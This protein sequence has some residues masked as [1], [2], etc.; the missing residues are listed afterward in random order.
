MSPARASDPAATT[1][2]PALTER[3]TVADSP[4]R[5]VYSTITTASAPAGTGAPVMIS[6][7]SPALTRISLSD[8]DAPALISPITCKRAG[9]FFVSAARTAKPS[10][11][12]LGN[13]GK[14]RSA[15]SSSA[16]ASP[17]ASSSDS[18]AGSVGRSSEAY[19]STRCRASGNDGISGSR[20]LVMR[21]YQQEFYWRKCKASSGTFRGQ[22]CP[23]VSPTE[24]LTWDSR[25]RGAL[26]LRC[27]RLA[28]AGLDGCADRGEHLLGRV[29]VFAGRLQLQILIKR[30][31]CSFGGDHLVVFHRR[32]AD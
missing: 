9:S 16:N 27:F 6:T 12:D 30:L 25:K 31:G 17:T 21:R 3:R 20:L 4:L 32:F 22:S 24:R 28:V 29:C 15:R 8:S 11:V 5:S 19:C 18:I 1:F 23:Q 10:R 7:A 26:L 13:G 14:S 2:S